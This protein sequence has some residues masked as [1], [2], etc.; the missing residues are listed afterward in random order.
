MIHLHLEQSMIY[1][2]SQIEPL[3]A[4]RMH[5]INKSSIITW[6]GPM[7]IDNS[8]I[9][10]YEDVGLEIKADK[11][12]HFI[13]EHFDCQPPD[14]RMAYHRQRILVMIVKE[15]LTE[16]N[17]LSYRKGDDIYVNGYKLS[18]SIATCSNSS[19][20]IHFGINVIS[21]GTP[22][23]VKTIGIN[24]CN[25]KFND[26]NLKMIIN[27]ICTKYINE[28]KSIDKDITKTRVF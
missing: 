16:H 20:K 28:I 1:D 13:I 22:E 8:K 10:D 3:W 26:D 4:F 24:E 19:L 7:D 6:I 21:E 17:I 23:D 11:M 27:E 15:V 2:G 14:M 12:I 25:G 5:K 9:L 18:V